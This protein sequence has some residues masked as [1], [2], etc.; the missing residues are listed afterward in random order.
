MWP[1][2]GSSPV[3]RRLRKQSSVGVNQLIHSSDVSKQRES[4]ELDNGVEIENCNLDK[5]IKLHLYNADILPV[6]LYGSECW[7]VKKA[8]VQ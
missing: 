3:I 8:D 5:T 2:R 6:M 7:M 1:P 4:A